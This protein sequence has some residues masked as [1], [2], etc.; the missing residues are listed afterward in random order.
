MND[1]FY[2]N[3]ALQLVA[4]AVGQTS[5][6][7]TVGAVIVRDGEIVGMGVH[8]KSGEPH[9]EIHA[10]NMAGT[11]AKKGILY[12]TLEPCSHYGRTS[13]CTDAVIKAGLEKV[14]IAST[15][16]NSL[17]AG[18]GIE[19]LKQA[20]IEVIMG[21]LQEKGDQLNQHF[22]H[23]IKQRKPFVT[24]KQAVTFDGKMAAKTG[25]S[26][27][28]S[29]EASRRDVHNDR[30]RN[31]AIM[32]GINTVLS[33]DPR[34]TNRNEEHAKQPIRLVLDT[35][36]KIPYTAKIVTDGAAPTWIITGSKA[37]QKKADILKNR[38]IFV[39]F[40]VN[41]GYF[42]RRGTCITREKRNYV[43]VC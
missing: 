18:K 39:F 13:P 8:L 3:Y 31:D 20:G 6:N 25:D 4:G 38:D 42:N 17:V 30:S 24:L 21:V 15:D 40:G 16:P 28:I 11:K 43:V 29:G 37:D 14:V 32:V 2:M 22:F 36:L 35:H 5:P 33:D 41:A 34:L 12:V 26:K 9:A 23:Y 7:P 10:L 27:W 19:K 1:E